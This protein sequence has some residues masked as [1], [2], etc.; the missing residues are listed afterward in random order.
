MY[1]ICKCFFPVRSFAFYPCNRAFH[2]AKVLN[3]D[4]VQFTDFFLLC[5]MISYISIFY[6]TVG[7][8]DFLL[9]YSISLIALYLIFKSM[10]HFEFI[11]YKV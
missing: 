10:I 2:T 3:F 11:A 7:P 1:A 4:A 5:I 9:F 6:Q 8:K